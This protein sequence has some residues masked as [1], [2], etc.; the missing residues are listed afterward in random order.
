MATLPAN[1][2]DAIVSDPPYGLE[3]MGKDW[4]SFRVDERS[5][6]WAGNE[7]TGGAGAGFAEIPG[8][9]TLPTYGKRRTTSTCRT[10]GKRDAFRN[11][12]P[13]DETGTADWT[14]VHVDDV[15]MEMR[16]FQNWCTTWAREALRVLKPGG[17][18]LA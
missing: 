5:A 1:S 15:P 4:D 18:L 12:H 2:V 13:C 7:R 16:A 3:F 6:R 17:H 10:C 8:G 11:P 14:T 9:S